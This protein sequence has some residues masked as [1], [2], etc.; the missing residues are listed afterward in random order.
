MLRPRVGRFLN[1]QPNERKKWLGLPIPFFPF[2]LNSQEDAA[3][4]IFLVRWGRERKTLARIVIGTDSTIDAELWELIHQLGQ[5]ELPRWLVTS[6]LYWHRA[7][8]CAAVHQ[9]AVLEL[10][11]GKNRHE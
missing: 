11:Q 4:P 5:D 1:R 6:P 9:W 7:S 3:G 8:W 2:E 10:A